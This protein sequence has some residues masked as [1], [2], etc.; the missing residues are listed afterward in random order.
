MLEQISRATEDREGTGGTFRFAFESESDAKT[1][2]TII[3]QIG[4]ST[5]G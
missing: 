2:K 5:K 3:E 1:A 4:F